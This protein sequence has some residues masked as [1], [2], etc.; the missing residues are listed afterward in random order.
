MVYYT[1]ANPYR[2][3]RIFDMATGT[4]T[5]PTA[6]VIMRRDKSIEIIGP[7]NPAFID[8]IK[9]IPAD[10]RAWHSERKS[11]IVYANWQATAKRIAAEFYVLDELAPVGTSTNDPN[12]PDD[13]Q[14]G[15]AAGHADATE[16]NK[17]Y[18]GSTNR[19][20]YEAAYTKGYEA[21]QRS[22][23]HT[24]RAEFEKGY[25]AGL[26]AGRQ[27]GSYSPQWQVPT[28]SVSQCLEAVCA[29][30]P[31][32]A[33]LG[34]MPRAGRDLLRSAYRIASMVKHPDRGGSTGDMVKVNAAY[35][36]LMKAL[37]P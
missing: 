6:F 22:Q 33:A 2:D 20:E 15:Y 11:W 37:I 10:Y 23:T 8:R 16:K 25:A 18:Y 5:K 21:G 3:T 28:H 14:A 1:Y 34:V 27:A 19:A 13:Y 35:E 4:K 30:W 9:N 36:R 24:S 17:Y 31:D 7:F 32:H 12:E 29:H 26:K